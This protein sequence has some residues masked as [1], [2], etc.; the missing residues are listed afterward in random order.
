MRKVLLSAM[1]LALVATMVGFG[2]HAQLSD[3]ELSITKVKAATL[4]LTVDG[5]NGTP[6]TFEVKCMK[7][8]DCVQK[9]YT[10]KNIGCIDG[11]V[12]IEDIKVTNCENGITEPE[13]EAGDTTPDAGE[14][15]DLVTILIKYEDYGVYKKVWEGLVKDLPSSLDVDGL[16]LKA[17]TDKDFVLEIIKWSDSPMDNLAQGDS[18]E[19][20]MKFVLEQ[21]KD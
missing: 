20:S 2:V 8:G 18:F 16:L 6:V 3:T 14:L 12:D 4:D 11:W 13:A 1:A 19:I 17:G 10:L 7:P 21:N 5:Q 15:Q 9:C